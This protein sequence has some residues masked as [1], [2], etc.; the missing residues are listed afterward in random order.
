MVI[1]H[2]YWHARNGGDEP[3]AMAASAAFMRVVSR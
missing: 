2:E 3:S 1:D